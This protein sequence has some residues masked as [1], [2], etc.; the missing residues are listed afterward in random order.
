MTAQPKLRQQ[1]V[2][3]IRRGTTLL[4]VLVASGILVIGLASVAALLPAAA[5][6]MAD[7][8]R[9]DRAANLGPNAV[10]N[11]RFTGLLR[12]AEFQ[13]PVKTLVIGEMFPD[14]PFNQPPF[15]KRVVSPTPLDEQAYGTAWFGAT[16]SPLAA[17]GPVR[18]GMSARVTV[19]V[20][21]RR[22]PESKMIALRRMWPGVYRMAEPEDPEPGAGGSGPEPEG[23]TPQEREADRKRFL[24]ACAWVAVQVDDTIRWLHVGNS[25]TTYEKQGQWLADKTI[26]DCF[27]S[28]SDPD[29]AEAASQGPTLMVQA[30]SG[31]IKLEEH[32]A[33]LD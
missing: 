17:D 20:F 22:D 27:V 2:A 19:V 31:V 18:K 26:Q 1:S 9:L 10:A 29:A 3:T 15:R 25:W 7:A 5:S 14:T 21:K 11:L 28:F 16:V 13:G 30:F 32:L 12:A 24:P 33:S 6:V 23:P 4:E 8:S